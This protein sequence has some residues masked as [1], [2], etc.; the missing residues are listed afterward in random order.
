MKTS[1]LGRLD[2]ELAAILDAHQQTHLVRFWSELTADQQ[3][4]LV[5]QIRALDF[6]LLS[7]LARHDP[8]R[9]AWAELAWSAQP[10]PAIRLDEQRDAARVQPAIDAGQEALAAGRVAAVMVAG[11]QATRMGVSEPKG[12]VPVGPISG[13]SLFQL[14]VSRLLAR[15]ERVGTSIPLWIMTSPA[16]DEATRRFFVHHRYFGLDEQDVRFFCQGTM[17]A[18]DSQ[19]GQILL[20]NPWTIC[21]SPDG[22]GGIVAALARSGALAA[23]EARRIAH[24]F[25]FQV[26]NPLA[27]ICDPA[28]I[29]FHRMASAEITLQAVRKSEPLQ[30]VGNI[31]S[32]DNRLG[33][34]EYIDLPADVAARR[35]DDGTLVLWAANIAVHV[36]DVELVKRCAQRDELPLHVQRK[37]VPYIDE[38]GTLQHPTEPNALKFERF[39]FDLLPQARRALVVEVDAADAFA[40]VKNAAGA[41]GETIDTA[42]AALAAQARRWLTQAGVSVGENIDVEIDPRLA[43]DAAELA[44]RYSDRSRID[45]PTY[46]AAHPSR[47]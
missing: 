43:L 17:P 8:Q 22:H 23:L 7:H 25:Y 19:T 33:V 47:E 31:V 5:D 2:A 3:E 30:R 38:H 46:L 40:P 29:G 21:A 39:V 28:T 15:A 13:H 45:Q 1:S 9:A 16:T 26:D 24:L 35:N 20:R 18:V 34:I 11:G 6:E 44:A 42:R 10:P 41:P 12:L 14:L 37:I 27:Q 36:I 4:Q 32:I